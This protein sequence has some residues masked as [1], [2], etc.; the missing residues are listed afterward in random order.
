MGGLWGVLTVKRQILLAVS[1]R[2]LV[3][4]IVLAAEVSEKA[5]KLWDP[6]GIAV[7]MKDHFWTEDIL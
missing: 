3:Q 1:M 2:S 4:L 7:V 5:L 6:Y